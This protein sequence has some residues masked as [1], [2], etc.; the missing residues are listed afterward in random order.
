LWFVLTYPYLLMFWKAFLLTNAVEIPIL[1]LFAYKMG[2]VKVFATGLLAN[3]LSLPVVWFIM[4]LVTSSYLNFVIF[5]ETFAVL[6][7]TLILR[8]VLFISYKRSL[9]AALAMNAMSFLVGWMF[10]SLLL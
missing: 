7:E 2:V 6:S 5:A 4:P 1:Y 8:K 9:T 3:G 10:P